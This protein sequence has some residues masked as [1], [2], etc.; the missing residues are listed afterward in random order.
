MNCIDYLDTCLDEYY[1]EQGVDLKT[2]LPKRQNLE[3]LA[4]ARVA[5][6]L[7]KLGIHIH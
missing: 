2:G 1:Q 4:L 7:V 6:K 5:K 3:Q